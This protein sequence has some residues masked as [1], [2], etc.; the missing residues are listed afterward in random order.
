VTGNGWTS[1]EVIVMGEP[2]GAQA[3]AAAAAPTADKARKATPLLCHGQLVC[4]RVSTN[5]RVS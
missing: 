1:F 3:A 5:P 4:L 2:T